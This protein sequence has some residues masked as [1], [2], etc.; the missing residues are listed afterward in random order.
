MDLLQIRPQGSAN[1]LETHLDIWWRSSPLPPAASGGLLHPV[2]IQVLKWLLCVGE[3]PL[4]R[5][6][7]SN[8]RL[9]GCLWP[10]GDKG[11]AAGNDPNDQKCDRGTWKPRHDA[12]RRRPKRNTKI[13]AVACSTYAS[14]EMADTRIACGVLLQRHSGPT[15][16]HDPAGNAAKVI[17]CT[18]LWLWPILTQRADN[19]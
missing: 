8:L 17:C 7:S 5:C 4:E 3:I 9:R 12:H 1:S 13:S 11:H 2:R 19:S 16:Q 10:E 14:L 6:E 18:R 15:C